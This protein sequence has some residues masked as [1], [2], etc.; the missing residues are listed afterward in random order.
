[1][2]TKPTKVTTITPLP[3]PP[4]REPE[5]MTSF[6]HLH[7]NGNSHHLARHFGHPQTTIVA[8]ERYVVPGPG[9]NTQPRRIPD[10]LIAF[11]A[12]PQAYKENNGYIISV[13]GKP[14]D[15]VLEIA[16]TQHG[17]DRHSRQT[18]G[19]CR[20]GNPRILAVRRDR[21]R[22][23]GRAGRGPAGGRPLRAHTN[24]GDPRGH[25]AGIQRVARPHPSVGPRRAALVRPQRPASTSLPTTP[26]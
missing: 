18:Q 14:P 6:E 22:T 24:R 23:W 2:T 5:D 17:R 20:A 15:F 16:S 19:L 12:D 7:L 13:Q 1:M 21:P 26:W 10:L 9:K 4:Q 3:D 11:D 8:A 25:T